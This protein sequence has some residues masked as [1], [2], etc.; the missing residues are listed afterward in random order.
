LTINRGPGVTARL[1]NLKV[2]R[3]ERKQI[4]N[5]GALSKFIAGIIAPE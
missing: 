4:K 3:D 1:P 2:V 5:S